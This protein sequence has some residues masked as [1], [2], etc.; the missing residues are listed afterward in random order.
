MKKF[1]SFL[2]CGRRL[3][4]LSGL[5]T[6]LHNELVTSLERV[7]TLEN[8]VGSTA[9]FMVNVPVNIPCQLRH[10]GPAVVS[11]FETC[12]R[13][14]HPEFIHNFLPRY[15]VYIFPSWFSLFGV[16]LFCFVFFCT[17]YRVCSL[18]P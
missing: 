9:I 17:L 18:S 8:F 7:A 4:S 1:P 12:G 3:N 10:V 15:D 13:E 2:T 14:I 11:Q 6:N 16:F 5:A